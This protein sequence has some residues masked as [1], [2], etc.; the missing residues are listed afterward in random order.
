MRRLALVPTLA[1]AL[2][3]AACGGT[4]PPSTTT[5]PGT[6]GTEPSCARVPQPESR[7]PGASRPPTTLLDPSTRWTL[8]F[9]TSCGT[10]VVLLQPRAA[11]HA[12]ASLVALAQ[13]AYFNGTVFHRIVPGFVIQ[14]GDPTQT[15]SGGPG[16]TTVDTPKAGTRYRKGVVAMAKTSAEPRGAAGSQFFVMSADAPSLDPDYAV[17]G[18]VVAGDSVVQRIGKL[19][20]PADPKGTPTQAVVIDRVT[21]GTR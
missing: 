10:F 2:V 13:G 4:A 12:T 3:A 16:Y 8:T 5:N 14:G 15:G 11:P 7:E 20:D 18:R 6:A 19:G 1:A 17:V 9:H 21:V